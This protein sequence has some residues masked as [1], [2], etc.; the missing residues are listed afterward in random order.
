MVDVITLT[1]KT[2]LYSSD[3][4]VTVLAKNRAP[5]T[6]FTSTSLATRLPSDGQ[7]RVCVPWEM[8][9]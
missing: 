4:L 9:P 5:V 1:R 6:T 8:R 7:S 3:G 2:C